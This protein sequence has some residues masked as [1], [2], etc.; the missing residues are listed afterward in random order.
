[1]RCSRSRPQPR[2]PAECRRSN[3]PPHL[4]RVEHDRISCTTQKE[5]RMSAVNI[6]PP[7]ALAERLQRLAALRTLMDGAG[8]AAVI[9]GSTKSLRYFTGLV[10]GASERFTGAIVHADG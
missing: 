9:L 4:A 3:A 5:M 7:I 10:W 1:C 8:L 2:P 6:A